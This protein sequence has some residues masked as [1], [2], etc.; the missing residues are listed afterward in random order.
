MTQ[1]GIGALVAVACILAIFVMVLEIIG[2][3]DEDDDA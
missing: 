3:G 1:D 2:G